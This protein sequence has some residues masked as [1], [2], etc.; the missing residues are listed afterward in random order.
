MPTNDSQVIS[1][2]S[3]L[4]FSHPHPPIPSPLSDT[5]FMEEIRDHEIKYPLILQ[6]A[7]HKQLSLSHSLLP[8]LDFEIWKK[9]DEITLQTPLQLGI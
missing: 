8:Y 4:T 9:R 2:S 6:L 1:Q 7:D 3:Q 5:R